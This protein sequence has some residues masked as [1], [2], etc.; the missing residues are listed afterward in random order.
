MARFGLDMRHM[1]HEPM[2][3]KAKM[4]TARKIVL[5]LLDY[6]LAEMKLSKEEMICLV[7]YEIKAAL[8]RYVWFGRIK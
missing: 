7:D 3:G 1:V 8:G 2:V 5:A 6:D 4:T